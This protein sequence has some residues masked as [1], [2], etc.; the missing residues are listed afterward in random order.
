VKEDDRQTA[1]VSVSHYV[2]QNMPVGLS[3][4]MTYLCD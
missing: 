3:T 4:C 2:E 1:E